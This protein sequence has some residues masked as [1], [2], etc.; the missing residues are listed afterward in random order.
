MS[1]HVVPAENFV[2]T[3]RMPPKDRRAEW[4]PSVSGPD[5]ANWIPPVE[6]NEHYYIDYVYWLVDHLNLDDR[7]ASLVID[8]VTKPAKYDSDFR[9]W[10][11]EMGSA[12]YDRRHG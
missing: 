3:L 2:S 11:D 6:V 8:M 4:V 10:M 9:E 12:D 7:T 5:F 1:A